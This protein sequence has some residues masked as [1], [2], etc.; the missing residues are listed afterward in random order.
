MFAGVCANVYGCVWACMGLH[1]HIPWRTS[2][3]MCVCVYGHLAPLGIQDLIAWGSTDK[4]QK[5][6]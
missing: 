6:S 3:F 1:V 4:E 5:G 2:V